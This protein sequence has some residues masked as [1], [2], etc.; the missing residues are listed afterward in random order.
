MHGIGVR[1]PM[2]AE[3]AAATVGFA[4]DIHTP[5]GMMLVIGI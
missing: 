4:S 5:K 2:A 3:V 1:T